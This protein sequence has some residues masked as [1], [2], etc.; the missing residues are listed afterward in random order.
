MLYNPLDLFVNTQRG[1]DSIFTPT[2]AVNRQ[3]NI[4]ERGKKPVVI[5][6]WRHSWLSHVKNAVRFSKK[7]ISLSRA[8]A[9]PVIRS[10]KAENERE[11]LE[12]IKM[13][14][15]QWKWF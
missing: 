13:I 9:V 8:K 6:A 2:V 4:G 11:C 14:A 12:N 3:Q 10:S 1:E 7:Q 15:P 5:P